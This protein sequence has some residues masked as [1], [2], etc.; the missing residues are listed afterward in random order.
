M[1]TFL[2]TIGFALGGMMTSLAHAQIIPLTIDPAQSSVVISIAG[3][4]GSSQ[5]SGD[6]TLD[7]QFSDPPSGD[8][9]ITDVNLVADDPININLFFG[10]IRLSTTPGDVTVSM[11]TPGEPGTISGSSFDQLANLLALGGDLNVTDVTGI[12]GGN[13]TVDLSTIDITPF[14]FT[15]VDVTQSGN[16]ITVSNSFLINETVDLGGTP[17]QVTVD[18]NYVATGEVPAL[19]RRGDVNRDTA[20]DF[21]DIA[22]FIAILS[23]GGFQAEADIDQNLMVDFSDIAPFITLLAGQ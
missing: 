2:L 7:L 16:V 4:P 13:Q 10:T 22:P 8:A 14:D 15:S 20:V 17:I 1:K 3:T 12:A 5:L 21:A 18:V 6:A 9:Q 23:A 19:V 11:V